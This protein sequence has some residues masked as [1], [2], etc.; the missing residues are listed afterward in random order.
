MRPDDGFLHWSELKQIGSSPKHY[1]SAVE[2]G[3][4]DTKSFLIG[5]AVHAQWLTGKL[6]PVWEGRRDLRNAEYR[7]AFEAAGDRLLSPAEAQTV[8]CCVDALN[9]DKWARFVKDQCTVFEQRIEWERRG[10]KCAGSFDMAGKY[11]T[12]GPRILGELKTDETA[13]PARWRYK[14]KRDGYH[15]QMSWYSVGT[16][17]EPKA[18]DTDWPECFCVVV[19]TKEPYDVV[20][21]QLD[22]LLLDQ[23]NA[24]VEGFLDRYIAC[25]QT[26]IWPGYADSILLWEADINY[27]SED[28]EA[29]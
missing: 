8:A 15:G 13:N 7:E 25:Q 18:F 20:V 1:K 28:E 29:A 2:H 21:H 5:R 14:A 10:I 24:M 19:E 26:G 9:R 17:V 12:N 11:A 22:G 23:G 16:G 27:D 3:I 6:F 4:G